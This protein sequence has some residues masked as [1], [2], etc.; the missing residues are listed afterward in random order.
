[1]TQSGSRW[2]SRLP[3]VGGYGVA[4]LS[5]LVAAALIVTWQ[6]HAETAPASLLFC[7]VMLSA[8]RG[9]LRAG[10]LATGLSLVAFDYYV[11]APDYSV[12]AQIARMP[13]LL[14]FA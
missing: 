5:V 2:L 13:R 10:L 7:A 1:M 11:I 4:L 14:V 3:V 6:H 8:C 12:A 9:G